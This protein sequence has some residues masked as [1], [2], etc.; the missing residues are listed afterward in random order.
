L[1]WCLVVQL[2]WIPS[3]GMFRAASAAQG[4]GIIRN[5]AADIVAL[6]VGITLPASEA[7]MRKGDKSNLGLADGT[8]YPAPLGA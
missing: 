3:M 2:A 1:V 5:A 4:W 7:A 8:E 6:T